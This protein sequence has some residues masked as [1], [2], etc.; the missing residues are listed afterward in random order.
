MRNYI[1]GKIGRAALAPAAVLA[2]AFITMQPVPAQTFTVLYTF[3]GGAD[4]GTPMAT[5]LLYNAALYGTT[6]GGGTNASGTI[7]GYSV[8]EKKEVALHSFA[9]SD[10]ADPIA[11]LVQGSNGN[12]YGVAYKG[13]AHNDGTLFEISPAGKFT[14]LNSFIGPPSEGI[15]PAGTL[16][17]DA[18]G[19]LFGTT[20]V[21]G[22]RKGW[23]TVFEYSA[24]GVFSTGQ[25]FSPDGALPRGG[26]NYIS[27]KLYGTT[28][29]GGTQPYGGTIY[30]VGVQAALYTFTGGADGSQPLASLIGDSQGNLYGTASEGGTGNFG[31]GYGVVFKFDTVT[32]QET[33][34]HTF[35]GPDGGA[36]T[37]PLTWDAQGNLYGTTSVGG[38]F[39]YGNVFKLD[40]SGNF[41]TLHDFTGGAD[42]ARSYAGVMVDAKGNVWGA[43][44]AGGSATAPGG[45]GALFVISPPAT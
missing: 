4:G 25:S 18:L 35:T 21:G 39:G 34:L 41:T 12:F 32:G 43:A 6:S 42:G 13:G 2:L 16:A 31:L 36:P 26:L 17:F 19:D 10:G 29:G 33:V 3:T 22:N 8:K 23:G 11:G 40:P 5:P 38:A 7:Y 37:A 24:A 9:G 20:Y 27:G 30:E 15:G 1:S 44:S 14:L 45:Y 28:F